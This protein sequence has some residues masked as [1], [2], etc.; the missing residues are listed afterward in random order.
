MR[1]SM[2]AVVVLL[3]FLAVGAAQQP[4]IRQVPIERSSWASGQQMYQEY[5]AAC[6]GENASGGGPAAAACVVKP[7]DL[8]TLA[9]RNG[10][11]FSYNYV[12]EVLQFGKTQ[13]TPAHGSTEMPIWLPLF[14]S[15]NNADRQAI[16]Q[17]RMYNLAHYL[18]SLQA[19]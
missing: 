5:C 18:A 10:G 13:S 1:K 14:S 16:A 11:K 19:K 8:T 7:P 9:R 4:T 2:L 15:L 12:Y 3:W 17:Q 6:H